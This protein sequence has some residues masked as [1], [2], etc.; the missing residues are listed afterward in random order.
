MS[1]SVGDRRRHRRG[2]PSERR[3]RRAGRASHRRGP[4]RRTGWS[5]ARTACRSSAPSSSARAFIVSNPAA[6]T[7]V[8]GRVGHVERGREPGHLRGQ[9]GAL[10][11]VV[12]EV[13]VRL[14]ARV[15]ERLRCGA[16]AL[17]AG[18]RA[19][20][21]GRPRPTCQNARPDPRRVRARGPSKPS[22]ARSSRPTALPG[23][24]SCGRRSMFA[25]WLSHDR[26]GVARIAGDVDVGDA[27]V[28]RQAVEGRV[29]LDEPAVRLGVEVRH[30][31][32]RAAGCSCRATATA[33][34][35]GPGG[36]A[37]GTGAARTC[38]CIHVVPHFGGVLMMMSSGRSSNAVPAIAVP[39]E[40]LVRHTPDSHRART[41]RISKVDNMRWRT[42]S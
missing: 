31:P 32:R 33:W 42:E 17:A 29:G 24:R 1:S 39:D 21:V 7:S 16:G 4:W 12:E 34:R 22:S 36:P 13:D 6:S 27:R 3:H 20:L 38:I 5:R 15:P 37:C 25:M 23:R 26:R 30:A 11:G 9:V 10:V 19:V 18:L 14:L 8:G 41:L 35:A 2:V 28:P 40:V